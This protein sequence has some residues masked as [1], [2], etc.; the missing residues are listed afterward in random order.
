MVFDISYSKALR[1]QRAQIAWYRQVVGRKGVKQIMK[2]TKP[3]PAGIHPDEPISI[4][5]INNLVPRGGA[6]EHLFGCK[7]FKTESDPTNL[8]VHEAIMR[9]LM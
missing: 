6:F 5:L 4:F 1:I 9:G 2:N 3:C 8:A 7:K